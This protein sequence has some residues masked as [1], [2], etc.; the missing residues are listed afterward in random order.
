M[1]PMQL[2]CMMLH[3]QRCHIGQQYF[4]FNK[5]S[6][7]RASGVSKATPGKYV[8]LLL[9]WLAL[10][11]SFLPPAAEM[12][13]DEQP[14]PPN[15]A[16]TSA[17]S[18]PLSTDPK[19]DDVDNTE[20]F[21][22]TAGSTSLLSDAQCTTFSVTPASNSAPNAKDFSN[23]ATAVAGSHGVCAPQGK[24]NH[25]VNFVLFYFMNLTA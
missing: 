6:G 12:P 9:S 15:T 23:T 13:G 8:I 20:N 3:S 16:A 24:G 2:I 11:F 19:K 1:Y 10:A 18:A 5:I 14:K 22:T 4:D 21:D 7:L 17:A 25:H